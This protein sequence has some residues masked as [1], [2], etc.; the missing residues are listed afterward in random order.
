MRSG[1]TWRLPVLF[2]CA[3]AL[4]V[5][6]GCDRGSGGGAPQVTCMTFE[7]P[8]GTWSYS[9]REKLFNR[10]H[11]DISL[12]IYHVPHSSYVTKLLASFAGNIAPDVFYSM[13]GRHR[14]FIAR[15]AFRPLNDLIEG[16]DGLDLSD[17]NQSILRGQLM[18]GETVYAL[19]Q[20]LDCLVLYYNKDLFEQ[21]GIPPLSETEPITWDE[22][23]E[24]AVRLTR[25]LD[26]DGHTDQ[27]GT[28][29]GFEAIQPTYFF[30]VFHEC[31]GGRAYNED[32]TRAQFD[33][34]ESA[35][36]FEYLHSLVY[37]HKCAMPPAVG[38]QVGA[39]LFPANR[40]GMF[41][42]GPWTAYD[43]VE[44]APDLNFG[45]APVPVRP[46]YP[47]VNMV[48]GPAVGISR[49]CTQPE[50][51]W[52]VVKWLTSPEFQKLPIQGLP[53]RASVMSAPDF[54]KI[55]FQH[56]FENELRNGTTTFFVP[57]YE[58]TT[59]LIRQ[60]GERILSDP[61]ARPRIPEM[62]RELND[63][64]NAVLAGG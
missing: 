48:G 54:N 8:M 12:K 39:S 11:D 41:I 18:R 37:E 49:T 22:Y 50:R 59:L 64:L 34:R 19:P 61:G 15:D 17:F 53:S 10:E 36:A 60:T 13:T 45:V 23:R 57:Q 43:Y 9:A 4:L 28:A 3:L 63:K 21:A 6:G 38:Q 30:Y 2:A 29:P 40:L 52:K 46:G 7:W 42:N 1:A 32:G 27:Y 16:A 5:A 56:V 26:G 25:D 47:R 31:F 58:Q 55:P 33:R 51:A 44:T 14:M 24:L 20:A 62:L 35:E